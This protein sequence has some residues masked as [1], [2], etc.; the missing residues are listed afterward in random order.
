VVAGAS[1]KETPSLLLSILIRGLWWRRFRPSGI[2]PAGHGRHRQHRLDGDVGRRVARR[3]LVQEGA[4]YRTPTGSTSM[5][6][7]ICPT[8]TEATRFIA[9]RSIISTVPGSDPTPSTEINA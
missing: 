6:P 1:T 7:A 3:H 9:C 4:R 5:P 8:S 2:V